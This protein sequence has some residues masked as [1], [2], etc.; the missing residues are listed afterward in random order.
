MATAKT[1]KKTISRKSVSVSSKKSKMTVADLRNKVF[2]KENRKTTIIVAGIVLLGVLLFLGRSFFVAATVNG[3]PLSRVAIIKEL[4]AQ[5]GKATLDRII[6]KKLVMQ[7]AAKK[8]IT[9]S[10]ADIDKEIARIEKQFKDQGQD[11]NQLLE[12]QGISKTQFKE[13]VKIQLLVEKMLGDQVKVT[14]EEFNQFL[15]QNKDLLANEKDQDQAKQQY[16]AQLEQ[17]KLAQKYQEWV[18]TLKKNAKIQH[19]VN[20]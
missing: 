6:T 3:E 13:E 4:E 7:E 8:K 9:A 11:L 5:N 10:S 16:R 18:A 1:A 19:F 12:A 2:A 17:Q 14:D 20:Y 15:E